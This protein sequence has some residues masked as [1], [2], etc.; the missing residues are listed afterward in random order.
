MYMYICMYVC[1]YMYVYPNSGNRVPRYV[2][3]TSYELE[4]DY[5]NRALAIEAASSKDNETTKDNF[6]SP[7]EDIKSQK[8]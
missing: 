2:A 5:A 8:L 6:V 1:M 3:T 7:L 4:V